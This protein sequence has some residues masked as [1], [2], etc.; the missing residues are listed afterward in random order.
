MPDY[1]HMYHHL[2]HSATDALQLL[3]EAQQQAWT[4]QRI[5]THAIARLERAQQE[6]EELYLQEEDPLIPLTPS[7]QEEE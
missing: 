2:F 3:Q 6:T 7:P 5:L 1:Q 4:Q